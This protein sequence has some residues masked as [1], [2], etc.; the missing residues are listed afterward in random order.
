MGSK[1]GLPVKSSSALNGHPSRNPLRRGP[2]LHTETGPWVPKWVPGPLD[3]NPPDQSLN[4]KL[5][6]GLRVVG[7]APGGRGAGTVLPGSEAAIRPSAGV[8]SE[9]GHTC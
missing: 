6:A 7:S 4:C 9:A 5:A 1:A 3:L 8:P 2:P